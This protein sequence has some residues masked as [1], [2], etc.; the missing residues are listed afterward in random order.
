MFPTQIRGSSPPPLINVSA[1]ERHDLLGVWNQDGEEGACGVRHFRM[2][3]G[4]GASYTSGHI[5]RV[6]FDT[7]RSSTYKSNAFP[8]ENKSSRASNNKYACQSVHVGTL[9]KGPTVPVIVRACVWV[10][11]SGAA[12]DDRHRVSSATSPF[13]QIRK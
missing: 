1:A 4:V 13:L 8:S 10:L 11:L 3:R 2:R 7:S 6:Y 5:H 12:N 9:R